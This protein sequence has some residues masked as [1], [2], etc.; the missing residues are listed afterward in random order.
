MASLGIGLS[1]VVCVA[2]QRLP[3]SVDIR[4]IV[5]TC[6]WMPLMQPATTIS[7]TLEDFHRGDL[8]KRVG[9]FQEMSELRNRCQKQQK[10]GQKMPEKGWE[11]PRK[12]VKEMRHLQEPPSS[13]PPQ[14]LSLALVTSPS[15]DAQSLATANRLLNCQ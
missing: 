8:Q 1:D 13:N 14:P 15:R 7:A 4:L 12:T 6:G 3:M 10:T 11:G 9:K 2:L 5:V